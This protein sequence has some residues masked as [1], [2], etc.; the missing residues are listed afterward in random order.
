MA[1]IG[2]IPE[3]VNAQNLKLDVGGDRYIMLQELDFHLGRPEAREPTTD[4]GVQYFYGKGDHFFDA[5]LLLTT[6]EISTFN[7][8][9][10]LDVNGDLTNTIFSIIAEPRGGGANVT[11]T[12][13][14]VLPDFNIVKPVEGGVIFRV[15][16]R[17]TDDTVTVS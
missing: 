16:F 8:L 9:T 7:A 15:R 17:I 6:P 4:G 3:L 14:A 13:D 10:E 12:V 1:N 5:T 11:I 2:E